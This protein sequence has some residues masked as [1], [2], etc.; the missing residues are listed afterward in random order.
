MKEQ[1]VNPVPLAA[2]AQPSLPADEAEV[3]TQL[4]E[5]GLQVADERLLQVALGVLVLEVEELQDEGVLDLFAGNH[6]VFGALHESARQHG[7]PVL[8]EGGALVE[9]GADLPVELADRPPTSQRLGLIELAGA[10]VP[11]R[12]QP[13]VG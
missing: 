1:Q 10:L 9:L 11:D 2:D 8:G 6:M 12:Q 4:Q 3:V 5:E 13:H 7:G